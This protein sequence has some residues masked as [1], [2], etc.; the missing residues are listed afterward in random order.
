MGFKEFRDSIR[1]EIQGIVASNF[2]IIIK[3]TEKVPF[4]DD[5]DI[6][7]PNL[8]TKEQKCKQIE[9]CILYI[10]IR[11]STD[12]NLSHR[13]ET[14]AKLYS[15]FVRAMVKAGSYY[16]GKVRNIIGDRL[17]VVFDTENCFTNAVNTAIL[18]N[19]VII[20]I[21][22]KEFPHNDIKCGI[23]IDFGKMLV[24]KTGIIK[25]G[26]ENT[27]NKSLVW[28]GRP[29]NVASK[30]TD[31]ANKITTSTKVKNIPT[32][33]EGHRYP[34][35][36]DLQWYEF[37][38]DYFLRERVTPTY[39]PVL[40]HNSDYFSCYILSSK[41]ETST[42]TVSTKSILMT[43]EVYEGF[44]TANPD[45]KSIT[46]SWGWE[47]QLGVSVSGYSKDIY[48]GDVI[49]QAFLE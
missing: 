11:K 45:D 43:K 5:P 39:S 28:L 9:T 37:S 18:M 4:I 35:Y 33:H 41:T 29:A 23:G 36:K 24:T 6:T 40:K 15:S 31:A 8:V 47:V 13:R 1:E 16:N 22:D 34:Q 30:L 2:N 27:S 21:L 44:K 14:M 10:D 32:I 20:Y 3:E 48:G 42:T 49:F 17:M 7:Y 26:T 38:Q 46:E 12:L 19:S 25:Q